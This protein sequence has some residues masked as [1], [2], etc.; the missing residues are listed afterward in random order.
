MVIVSEFTNTGYADKEFYVEILTNIL[1]FLLG[2][3]LAVFI[4]RIS[5]AVGDYACKKCNKKNS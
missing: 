5:R 2:W 3:C 1:L 4:M